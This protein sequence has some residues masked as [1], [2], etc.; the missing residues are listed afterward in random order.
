MRKRWLWLTATWLVQ[1]ARVAA[2]QDVPPAQMQDVA[3]LVGHWH[4]TG[5]IIVDGQRLTF[6]Q[7]EIVEPRAD[8]AVLSIDGLGKSADPN[9]PGTVIHSAFGMVSWDRAA[10]VFRW[11]AVESSGFQTATE[12]EVSNEQLVWR[13]PGEAGTAVRYTIRL[14]A[15]GQ[16]FEIGEREQVGCGWQKF[17]EMTLDR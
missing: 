1:M 16:W 14:N 17:F 3:F 8:G 12:A 13:T 6:E 15:R 7:T 2:A 10:E 5:W 4:G 11:Y 9:N